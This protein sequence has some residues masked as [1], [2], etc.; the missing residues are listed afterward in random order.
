MRRNQFK[1]MNVG[2]GHETREVTLKKAQLNNK[3][4]L[5]NRTE[6][7]KLAKKSSPRLKSPAKQNTS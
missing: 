4:N 1:E 2:V 5:L 7:E 3:G 6:L